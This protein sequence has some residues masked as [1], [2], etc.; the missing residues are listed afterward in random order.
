M[1]FRRIGRRHDLDPA[2]YLQFAI[3]VVAMWLVNVRDG[4]MDATHAFLDLEQ[5]AE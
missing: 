5:E 4:A 1:V 3:D 2:E